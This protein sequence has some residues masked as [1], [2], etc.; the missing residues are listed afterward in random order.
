MSSSAHNAGD[1]VNDTIKRNDGGARDGERELSV[2]LPGYAG[3]EGGR[4]KDRRQHQCDG[5]QRSA[6]FV[7]AFDCGVVRAKAR[8]DIALDV[9]HHDDGVVDHYADRQHEAEQ[10][11]VVE[12]KAEQPP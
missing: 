5:D 11:Q 6:H 7:H 4:D 10:R 9:L 2:E 12:R 8:L 1:N 3:D